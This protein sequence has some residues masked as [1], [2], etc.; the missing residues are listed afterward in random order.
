LRARINIK[1]NEKE[2]SDSGDN[3]FEATMP[4]SKETFKPHNFCFGG[5]K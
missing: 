3:G 5:E 4:A 1:D 2:S